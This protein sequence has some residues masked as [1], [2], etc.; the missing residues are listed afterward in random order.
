MRSQVIMILLVAVVLFTG[1]KEKDKA[2]KQSEPPQKQADQ[3]AA[4]IVQPLV[5][6]GIKIED[7]PALQAKKVIITASGPFQSNVVP[8]ADP[9]RI[10]VVMHNTT[11]GKNAGTIKVA[12]GVIGSLETVQLETG[13]DPA[14]RL[15]I[16]LQTKAA[17]KVIPGEGSLVIAL[18][19][20]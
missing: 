19:K 11:V 20:Q 14:V 3:V 18:R 15:T 17:Y 8:K 6:E 5:L 9:D 12:D 1:C 16:A 13:K 4:R 2:S 10:L 7:D